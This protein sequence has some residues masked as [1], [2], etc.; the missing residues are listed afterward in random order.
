[1]HSINI[2]RAAPKKAWYEVEAEQDA[3]GRGQHLIRPLTP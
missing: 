1:M 2:S 3:Q